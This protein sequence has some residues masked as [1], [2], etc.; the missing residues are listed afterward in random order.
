MPVLPIEVVVLCNKKNSIEETTLP[1]PSWRRKK[2]MCKYEKSCTRKYAMKINGIPR[3]LILSWK[4][5]IYYNRT[6]GGIQ[7]VQKHST[8]YYRLYFPFFM[9]DYSMKRELLRHIFG[10]VS[11]E[12]NAA[13]SRRPSRRMQPL[14]LT[15][16]WSKLLGLQWGVLELYK[17]CFLHCSPLY[18]SVAV[19]SLLVAMKVREKVVAAVVVLLSATYISNKRAFRYKY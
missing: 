8:C 1:K 19:S 18:T 15:L 9:L 10:E 4:K 16:P 3:K 11:F 17:T 5:S 13:T 12:G 14:F 7:D 2:T 6:R